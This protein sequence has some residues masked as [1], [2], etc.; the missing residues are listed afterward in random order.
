MRTLHAIRY[1]S[2][3]Q[4]SIGFPRHLLADDDPD[5]PPPPLLP[6]ATPNTVPAHGIGQFG[7]W[8]A[9][10]WVEP[11]NVAQVID[12]YLVICDPSDTDRMQE[13]MGPNLMNAFRG[14]SGQVQFIL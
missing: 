14:L 7:T 3:S 5:N 2:R 1:S 13:R 12:E 10:G 8:A 4:V 11:S 9:A 6:V